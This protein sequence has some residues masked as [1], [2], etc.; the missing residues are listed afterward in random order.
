MLSFV[1]GDGV[2]PLRWAPCWRLW[3]LWLRRQLDE[4][5]KHETRAL[6]EAGSLKGLWRNRKAFLM[7]L[8][9]TAAGS[10]CFYTFTTYMQKYL[11][12][13]AGMHANVASGIMTA[14]LCVFM[15]VQPLF[16]A[17]SDKIGRRTSMLCFGALATLFTVPILSAL[18][19]VTS[20]YAAFALVICALLIVSFYTS[21]SGILKAEM[22]P[23]QVRALGVGLSYA[24]AN[25]LFGGSAEYVA[26][27]LK[28]VRYGEFVLLV[29]YRD[30][31]SGFPGFVD[32]AP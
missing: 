1:P 8:G 26:L 9:F 19:N 3:R 12:N 28:S 10:L 16:G 21:I 18:Q 22:F 23:A 27:S 13:T 4:T 29:C 11:V 6:K 25:A 31:R 14:A 5:S 15:L 24:V 17:L 30:G 20:P 2:F 32:V 7:V